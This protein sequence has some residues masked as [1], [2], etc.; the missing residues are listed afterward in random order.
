M[1]VCVCVY[2]RMYVPLSC[3]LDDR[4]SFAVAPHWLTLLSL[5]HKKYSSSFARSSIRSNLS[6]CATSGAITIEPYLHVI[7]FATEPCFHI[8][9]IGLFCQRDLSSHHQLFCQRAMTSYHID[10]FCGKRKLI[11]TWCLFCQKAVS[12]WYGFFVV[13]PEH[14]AL[15]CVAACY[16]VRQCVAVCCSVAVCC[17]GTCGYGSLAEEKIV[18]TRVK[19]FLCCSVLHCVAVYCNVLQCLIVCCS[20]LLCSAVCCN[21]SPDV[22]ALWQKRT[23]FNWFALQCV[24]Q[25]VLVCCNP[26]VVKSWI[27]WNPRCSRVVQCVAV[28]SSVMQ[29]VAKCCDLLRC[30]TVRCNPGVVTSWIFWNLTCCSVLLR[31]A[32]CYIVLHCVEVCCSAFQFWGRD[33]VNFLKLTYYIEFVNSTN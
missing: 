26:R 14:S 2:T 23:S 25:C 8:I 16:S 9:L 31:V 30:A 1:R 5:L 24:T 20:M 32:A 3:H 21:T 10:N 17:T 4:F 22:R 15:Q 11:G 19:A 18:S 29:F 33:V 28:C 6:W 13:A 12:W 7:S 27:Y